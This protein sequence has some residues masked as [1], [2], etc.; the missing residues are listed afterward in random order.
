[1]DFVS[2]ELNYFNNI[3]RLLYSNT[4]RLVDLGSR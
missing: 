2:S 1:M 4:K 3:L